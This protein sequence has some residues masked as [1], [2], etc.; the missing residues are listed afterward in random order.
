MVLNVWPNISLTDCLTGSQ[1]KSS[2]IQNPPSLS[3]GRY[4]FIIYLN[5]NWDKRCGGDLNIITGSGIHIPIQ[6]EYNKLV[7][8]DIKS[9]EKPHY[10]N[11]V[12][13]GNRLA[14]TGWFM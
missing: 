14:I 4:A 11:T 2:P 5:E 12:K 13:C 1:S 8:M 6:P 9:S 7:L 3:L 10:I